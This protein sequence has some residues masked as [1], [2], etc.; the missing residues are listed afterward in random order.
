MIA[1]LISILW[2]W[3]PAIPTEVERVFITQ[4]GTIQFSSEAP[5]ELIE[6]DSDQ[7]KGAIDTDKRTFAFTVEMTS[8]EGFNSPLQREHFNEIYME[9]TRFPKSKFAGKI[10][11]E[12]DFSKP[13]TYT[14]RAKGKLTLHG[15]TQERIIRCRL[16]VSESELQI[17]A[18]FSVL[19]VEHDISIPRVVH[20]KIAEEIK[21]KVRAVF[22]PQTGS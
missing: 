15:L 3:S 16:V 19:L 8:F 7:L 10:I 6:A 21:V 11:E 2:M 9:S 22:T 4:S 17:A 12:I 13:G 1:I 18:D 20:Q 14:I 5:L